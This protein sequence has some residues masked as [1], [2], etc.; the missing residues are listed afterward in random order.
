MKTIGGYLELELNKAK[1]HYQDA[2]RLNSGRNAFEYILQVRG[3]DKVYLPYYTCDAML[4]PIRRLALEYNFYHIDEKLNPVFN[5]S[6]LGAKDAFVYINY[7][8]ICDMQISQTTNNCKNI[9]IDNSQAFFSKP[10]SN[11][12]TFYSP[13]KFFGVPDG[14]YLYINKKIP[15]KFY[16]DISYTHFNHLIKRVD[17]N[18]ETGYADFKNNEGSFT[19]RPIKLMSKL[20]QRMLES[21]DYLKIAKKRRENFDYLHS[22]LKS[23]NSLS[24]NIRDNMVPMVYPYLVSNG[25]KLKK[26]LISKKIYVATYWPN[27]LENCEKAS[28]EFALAS[29]IVCLPIDQRYSIDE[30]TYLCEKINYLT[31]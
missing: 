10:L 28:F 11:I 31:S 27:V 20:T 1:E 12:D 13:R 25:D 30:M 16:R 22:K 6:C 8:G 5:F 21:F 2:I 26:K 23:T 18:V 29:N 15:R 7:F 9:S 17:I 19:D 14:A 4:E 24:L 3:Y